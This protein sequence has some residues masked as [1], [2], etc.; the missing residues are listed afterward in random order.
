MIAYTRNVEGLC[1]G[2][3]KVSEDYVAKP[4]E[5]LLDSDASI[6]LDALSD[7]QAVAARDAALT[8]ETSRLE[9]LRKERLAQELLDKLN[10]STP[11][12]IS[13]FVDNQIT[14][15]PSA[16]LMFKRILLLLAVR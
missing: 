6:D 4:G 13:D 12:Q 14:D 16:R 2:A 5:F 7:P 9:A 3:W 11:A 15:L 10:S 8:A 1:T